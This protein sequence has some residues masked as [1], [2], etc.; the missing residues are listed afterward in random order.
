[1]DKSYISLNVF[2]ETLQFS[3]GVVL[4]HACRQVYK[5]AQGS[6][7]EVQ[8]PIHVNLIDR[9]MAAPPPVLSPSN[10][11]P[12]PSSHC[13]FIPATKSSARI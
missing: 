4:Q 11:L 1:V 12:L 9:V 7:V 13:A 3:A 8:T 5:Y 6:P 10:I 2:A